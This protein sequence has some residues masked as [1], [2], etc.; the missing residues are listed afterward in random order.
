MTKN[1][2]RIEAEDA[3]NV[4]N[5][6]PN[7][8]DWLVEGLVP[9]KGLTLVSAKPKAGKS[10]VVTQMLVDVAEER[11]FLGAFP[12]KSVDSLYLCL[13]GPEHYAGMRFRELG[14][15]GNRGK[16]QVSRQRMADDLDTSLKALRSFLD[17]TSTIGLMI[18]DTLPKLLRLADS[19]KYDATVKA[20]ENLEALAKS[21]SLQIVCVTHLKKRAGD[22]TGD[23]VMGSTAHRGA[24]D[25]NILITREGNQRIIST[26]QRV[27][28][29]LEPHQ[30][31]LDSETRTLSLGKPVADV[32]EGRREGHKRSTKQRIESEITA[33]LLIAGRLNQ[34]G[35]RERVTGK[36]QDTLSVLREMETD[37]RITVREE[38]GAKWYSLAAIESEAA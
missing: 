33:A 16:I 6:A 24:S 19:D 29:S 34:S 8:I 28:E 21:H 17:A 25:T 20:M 37:K 11:P 7:K 22:E 26:E 3:L 5:K 15:S 36:A 13:E 35:I 1:D 30:L 23:A 2:F 18:V 10:T 14:Y 31:N 12:T 4:M 32:E 38:D 27:G 9:A